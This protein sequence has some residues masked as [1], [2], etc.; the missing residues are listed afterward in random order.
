MSRIRVY[1][2]EDAAEHAVTSALRARGVDV[3]TT[4]EAGRT[5]ISDEEQLLFA[6]SRQRCLY[7]FNVRDYSR[8]HGEFLR[9]GRQHFGII[10]IPDQR[11]SVGE[12]VR[13]IAKLVAVVTGEEMVN[14]IEFL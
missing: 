8:L 10:V 9:S 5:G 4:L 13:R 6:V 7:S 12:K 3:L 14:R 11:Y 1:V 2:D